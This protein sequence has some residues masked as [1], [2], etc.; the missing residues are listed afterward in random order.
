MGDI[1]RMSIAGLALFR[2]F[3]SERPQ[4]H[5]DEQDREPEQ[6]PNGSAESLLAGEHAAV[7]IDRPVDGAG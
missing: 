4:G 7:R 6:R 3:G 1:A 5:G 2:L